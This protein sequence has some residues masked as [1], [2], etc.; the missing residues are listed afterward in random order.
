MFSVSQISGNLVHS[1]VI[2]VPFP[3]SAVVSQATSLT[4]DSGSNGTHTVGIGGFTFEMI[5]LVLPLLALIGTT[6]SRNTRTKNIVHGSFTG[7][8]NY[9]NT[10]RLVLVPNVGYVP[11]SKPIPDN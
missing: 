11:V 1:A 3:D 4:A 9:R 2:N 5:G 7:H 6:G 8:Q 10:Y